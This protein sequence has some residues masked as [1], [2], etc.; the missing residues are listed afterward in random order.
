MYLVLN[1]PVPSSL[2]I[3]Q[4]PYYY[5]YTKQAK[6]TFFTQTMCHGLRNPK[7]HSLVVCFYSDKSNNI[8]TRSLKFCLGNL[9]CMWV[10]NFKNS[11]YIH[12]FTMTHLKPYFYSHIYNVIT[13]LSNKVD[14][15]ANDT[16]FSIFM[17]LLTR[18]TYF[19]MAATEKMQNKRIYSIP[20]FFIF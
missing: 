5:Y 17:L 4:I 11:L 8:S 3:S 14:D 19:D 15:V 16:W 9:W 12:H 6:T 18:N 13:S 1:F 2:S 7:V 20:I 10:K